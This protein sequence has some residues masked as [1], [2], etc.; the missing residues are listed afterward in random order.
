MELFLKRFLTFRHGDDNRC[1]L[2]DGHG[3][4]CVPCI[5]LR[6]LVRTGE[7]VNTL[8]FHSR[9]D[10]SRN[11]PFP[12][13]GEIHIRPKTLQFWRNSKASKA[14][15]TQLAFDALPQITEM[16]TPLQ[17]AYLKELVWQKFLGVQPHL[18]AEVLA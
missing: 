10:K 5:R 1:F 12:L 17:A 7:L 13:M 8:M 14:V 16:N 9:P 18:F 2:C 11:I 6:N 3:W 15:I 4:L